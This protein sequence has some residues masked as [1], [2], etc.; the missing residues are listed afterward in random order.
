MKPSL[1]ILTICRMNAQRTSSALL[2]IAIFAWPIAALATGVIYKSVDETGHV[3]YSTE[4]PGNAVGAEAMLVPRGPSEQAT[5]QAIERARAMEQKTDARFEAMAKRR[6]EE[7]QARRDEE[8]LQLERE[9]AERR[10]QLDDSSERFD[11]ERV[12]YPVYPRYRG[13]IYP[14]HPPVHLPYPPKP[15]HPIVRPQG[16]SHSHINPPTRRWLRD[17]GRY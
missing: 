15:A 3:T 4:P 12:Y 11:R 1:Q 7:A 16:P 8:R 14:P 5:E 17:R 2:L 6:R 9:A 10:R 13:G